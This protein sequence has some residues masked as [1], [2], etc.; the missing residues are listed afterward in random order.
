MHLILEYSVDCRISG[1][2]GNHIYKGSIS[3]K[4]GHFKLPIDIF[5]PSLI[6]R[7]EITPTGMLASVVT[8]NA[9]GGLLFVCYL[10]SSQKLQL[11]KK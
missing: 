2:I 10:V 1:V 7:A 4:P 8:P 11:R 9:Y 5:F 6:I 3:K